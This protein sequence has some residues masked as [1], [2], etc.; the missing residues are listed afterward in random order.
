MEYK[1]SGFHFFSHILASQVAR[2]GLTKQLIPLSKY[3]VDK[4]GYKT[5]QTIV[6]SLRTMARKSAISGSAAAKQ[7]AKI[8]RSSVVTQMLTFVVFSVPETYSFFSKKLS[9]AQYTKNMLSLVGTMAGA[10][11]GTL[12]ASVAAAKI[13]GAIGTTVA[14]GV[15]TA[16][17][18]AGGLLGGVVGGTVVKAVGDYIREDDSII[19]SRLFNGIVINMVYEYMLSE[20]ELDE[21]I[22]KLDSIKPKEFKK[23]FKNVIA[24]E[25][26]EQLIE[27][28][29]RNFYNDI[30]SNRPS[31]KEPTPEDLVN[32]MS[33]FDSE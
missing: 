1:Y 33:E 23:L 32:L 16:I 6:N 31:I 5:V 12:G 30:I 21:L 26:Q 7:L 9:S 24:S 10:G 14:P 2:T 27:N 20:S 29:I 8:L 28:F 11:G 13:A 18:I 3:I 22:E 15:G 17:G 25:N 19:I 4:M